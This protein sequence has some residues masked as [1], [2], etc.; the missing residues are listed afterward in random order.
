MHHGVKDQ[1]W[2]L[3]RW[4][5]KDGTLTTAG[6]YHYYGRGKRNKTKKAYGRREEDIIDIKPTRSYEE[7]KKAANDYRNLSTGGRDLSKALS[8]S[9]GKSVDKRRSKSSYNKAVDEALNMTTIEMKQRIDRMKTEN[10]YIY[11]RTNELERGKTKV[12]DVLNVVGDYTTVAAAGL[13]LYGTYLGIKA[14]KK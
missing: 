13:G 7:R 9:I 6:Y 5:N 4:Q 1:K 2:G 3:R 12:T 10:E 14:M 11:N 8:G